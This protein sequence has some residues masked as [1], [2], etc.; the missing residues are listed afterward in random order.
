MSL[1]TKDEAGDDWWRG[2][3]AMTPE[4]WQDSGGQREYSEVLVIQRGQEERHEEQRVH[5][6]RGFE[7]DRF[8]DVEQRRSTAQTTERLELCRLGKDQHVNNQTDSLARASHV[9]VAVHELLR[10][11]MATVGNGQIHALIENVL[12]VGDIRQSQSGS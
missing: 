7:S 6:D 3:R 9:D 8:V 11:D 10:E 1:T 4:Q 12:V 5:Y 2:P